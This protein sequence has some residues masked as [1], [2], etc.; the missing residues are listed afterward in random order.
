MRYVSYASGAGAR[1]GILDG[2][3]VYDAGF[4]GDMVA[5]IAAGAPG[6]ERR[7]VSDAQLLAPLRPRSLRDFL[8]FEGHLKNA[9]ARLG[10]RDP[11]RVVRGARLLQGHAR[12]RHRTRRGRS[13]GRPGRTGSTMS[14]SWPP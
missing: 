12:H 5:F 14:W 10:S 6:G 7:P 2:D 8:A 1:V 11:G 3:T 13:R 9:Y 4:D